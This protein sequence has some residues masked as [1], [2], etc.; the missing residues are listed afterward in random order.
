MR[1][2]AYW[3]HDNI[4]LILFGVVVGMFFVAWLVFEAIRSHSSRDE[5]F[6]LRQRLYELEREKVGRSLTDGPPVLASRWI[7]VGGAATTSDGGCLIL[8]EAVS[9]VQ[10]RALM[11]VR[12]DGYPAL[13]NEG[14]LVGQRLEV[15]GKSGIYVV[16]LHGTAHK[17]ARMAVSL[18]SRH[19]DYAEES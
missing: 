8:V 11:T 18:R 7:N 5:I 14:V 16:E 3:I 1:A 17:Q 12:V 10:K 9:P 19:V 6:R 4:T 15:E 13:K 2:W